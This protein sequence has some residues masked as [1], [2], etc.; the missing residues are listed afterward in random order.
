MTFQDWKEATDALLFSEYCL[1]LDDAGPSDQD[2]SAHYQSGDKPDDYV[3]WFA[4][5]YDLIGTR[6]VGL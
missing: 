2:L 1:T 4:E 5:K 6:S 3:S